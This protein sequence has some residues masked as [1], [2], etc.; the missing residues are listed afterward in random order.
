MTADGTKAGAIE[1]HS[2]QHQMFDGE[3]QVI[4]EAK[5]VIPAA[6]AAFGIK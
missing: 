1:V 5:V 3:G 6:K 2:F 4:D